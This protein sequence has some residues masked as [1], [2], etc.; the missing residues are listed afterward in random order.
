M[1]ERDL[2]FSLPSSAKPGEQTNE[3]LGPPAKRLVLYRMRFEYA[4]LL[5]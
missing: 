1:G 3:E 5:H 2:G 4:A